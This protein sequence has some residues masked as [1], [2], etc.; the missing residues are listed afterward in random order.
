MIFCL[1]DHT[2][3][4]AENFASVERLQ[5]VSSFFAQHP[6]PSTERTVQQVLESIKLNSDWL[7]RDSSIIRNYLNSQ[8]RL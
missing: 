7:S 3:H 5:E 2:Q 8:S 4:L 6:F 1:F